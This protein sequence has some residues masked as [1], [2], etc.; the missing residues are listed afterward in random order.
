MSNDCLCSR[1]SQEWLHKWMSKSQPS[2]YH[3]MR[4]WAAEAVKFR[5]TEGDSNEVHW[6]TGQPLCMHV[7]RLGTQF[8]FPCSDDS[9]L[10]Q[11]V[12]VDKGAIGRI[13]EALVSAARSGLAELG[14][15]EPL[16]P[17][18]G[19]VKDDGTAYSVLQSGEPHVRLRVR[20]TLTGTLA[21]DEYFWHDKGEGR[22]KIYASTAKSYLN[23]A[24]LVND[25]LLGALFLGTGMPSRAT[26]LTTIFYCCSRLGDRQVFVEPGASGPVLRLRTAYNKV[27]LNFVAPHPPLL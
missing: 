19:S 20:E 9:M 21:S 10:Y 12:L 7:F 25:A 8:A 6:L 15:T 4:S 14:A 26:E 3:E 24:S 2:P 1:I 22:R 11:G 18:Y 27:C 5:A 13:C 16:P 23:A 17:E